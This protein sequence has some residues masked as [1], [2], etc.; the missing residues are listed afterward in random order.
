MG[1]IN[2]IAISV[3]T[4]INNNMKMNE[5]SLPATRI[6]MTDVFWMTLSRPD[7]REIDSKNDIGKKLSHPGMDIIDTMVRI[8]L[9][10][11]LQLLL[12]P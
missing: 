12:R 7:H 8:W 10:I 5:N 3:I 2:Q 1:N 6:H 9:T 11:V 4:E